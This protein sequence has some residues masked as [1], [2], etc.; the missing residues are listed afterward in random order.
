M[1][2]YDARLEDAIVPTTLETSPMSDLWNVLTFC[3]SVAALG[4]SLYSFRR[5]R[6]AENRPIL[7]FSNAEYIPGMKTT[8]TVENVGKGPAIN[9][10][11][12]ALDSERRWDD[13]EWTQIPA[14]PVG[15]PERLNAF[16]RGYGFVAY[17]Q[18]A[19]GNNYRSHC[20]ENTNTINE[21]Y[22]RP[23]NIAA[24]RALWSLRMEAGKGSVNPTN[25]TKSDHVGDTS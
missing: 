7:I 22:P 23:R 15:K 18:D 16:K 14:L 11:L 17:Y 3:M 19:L 4:F 20:E 24:K 1:R 10:L 6:I 2:R 12:G 9:V 25:T 13:S 21:N 8:W 5:G